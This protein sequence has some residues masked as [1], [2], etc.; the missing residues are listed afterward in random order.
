MGADWP[1]IA[2]LRD[3]LVALRDRLGD[4]GCAVGEPEASRG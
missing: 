2:D 1:E 3:R 4:T